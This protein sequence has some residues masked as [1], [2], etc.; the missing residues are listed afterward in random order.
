VLPLTRRFI[1]IRELGGAPQIAQDYQGGALATISAAN[2]RFV[3]LTRDGTAYIGGRSGVQE[4]VDVF[5]SASAAVV[6][7][8]GNPI[9]LLR[10]D[11]QTR[12]LVAA[13]L[14]LT[15]DNLDT[16][17]RD[18]SGLWARLPTPAG[19]TALANWVEV[20]GTRT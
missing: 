12:S 20:I 15:S 14:Q 11:T 9:G 4:V 16:V 2:G 17:V 3:M 13:V 5:G 19:A 1:T 6:T 7:E 10:V 18:A 8:S